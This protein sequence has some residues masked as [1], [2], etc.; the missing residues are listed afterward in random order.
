VELPVKL[1]SNLNELTKDFYNEINKH[2]ADF[3]LLERIE[4]P[5]RPEERIIAYFK[6]KP[7]QAVD[8]LQVLSE[9]H[10]RCL[11]LSI[12][13]SKIV[14]DN[15]NIIIFD[16][17]VNAI[18]DDHRG[19]IRELL[20]NSELLKNKQIILTSHAEEFIKDLENQVDKKMYSKLINRI[21]F[22]P[23]ENRIIRTDNVTTSNYLTNAKYFLDRSQKR[24]CL[25]YC[26]TALEN[27]NSSLWKRLSRTYNAVISVQMRQPKGMPDTMSAALGL[28]KFMKDL[29][30]KEGNS[31]FDHIIEKYNFLTGLHTTNNTV[32]NYLN[33]GT[34][35]EEGLDEFDSLLVKKIYENLEALDSEAKS[36]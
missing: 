7:N 28:E 9:G 18:D 25:R 31:K 27:I 8:A 20:F 26:R 19:G 24:E 29:R 15:I 2:D 36:V 14:K 30:K 6:D 22:L 4:L 5:T 32:W 13:L 10:I 12:L 3:E 1:I 23:P 16:D 35:E 17:V 33:K 11:G 21:T 34:H